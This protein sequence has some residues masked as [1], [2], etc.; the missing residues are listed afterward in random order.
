MA[1]L[2]YITVE[3]LNH[4]INSTIKAEEFFHNILVVGEVSGFK[5]SGSHAYFTLKDKKAQIAV[6][7]FGYS[8]KYIPKEGEQIVIKGD[9]EYYQPNGKLSLIV[10]EIIPYGEGF[11]AQ[12]LEKLKKDLAQK[13][14]FN[15]DHKKPIPKFPQN[16]CVITSKTGAVI[17]DIISTTRKYNKN[18]NIYVY[19][20]RVQGVNADKDLINALKVVDKLNFDVIILARGGGSLEDLMPFNSENLV[21]AIYDAKTPI[22]SAVGH[23]TDFSL[24]DY[25]ADVRALT[26]TAAAQII[27]Y[28][29]E[30]FIQ[31]FEECEHK[32]NKLLSQISTN[33]DSKFNLLKNR[34]IS[35]F[36]LI[37]SKKSNNLEKYMSKMNN[38]ANICLIKKS[39][40][41]KALIAKIAKHVEKSIDANDIKLNK[42]INKLDASNPTTIFTK[43]YM[44][45]QK[46]GKKI[47][48]IKDLAKG[49]IIN[50]KTSDGSAKAKIE[51]VNYEI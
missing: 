17:K 6:S 44:V 1:N 38:L 48:S 13:G 39:N 12:Q 26:P 14:Y 28:D 18:I 24:S 4:Y 3:A 19:D 15:D 46:D 5:I 49:D 40:E 11:L 51:E 21:Y 2:Q 7:D 43:G 9:L 31:Y 29:E 27:A 10:K 45:A 8:K 34:L 32:L 25:V 36:N 50:L 20:A 42:L 41:H 47:K 16:V 30:K 23:E 33:A 22:I 37:Y 35:S